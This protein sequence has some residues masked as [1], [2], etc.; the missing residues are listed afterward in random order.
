[1]Y[2]ADG[3]SIR[4]AGFMNREK[5]TRDYCAKVELAD[6][7]NATFHSSVID[8]LASTVEFDLQNNPELHLMNTTAFYC[9][10][11]TVLSHPYKAGDEK[12]DVEQTWQIDGAMY[13][14]RAISFDP[15]TNTRK[16][17]LGKSA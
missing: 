1:M 13:V 16:I 14:V 8:E 7:I 10:D 15:K 4:V 5:V 9:G 3:S 2:W 6:D 12:I 11:T 17:S